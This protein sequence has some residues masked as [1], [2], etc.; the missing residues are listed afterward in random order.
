MKILFYSTMCNFC[1]DL[2]NKLKES[3]YIDEFKLVN[4]NESKIP[5][6]IKVVPTIIDS[7]VKDL[8]EGK[9]AFEYLFNKKYFN[10]PTN[11]LH[12]WLNKEI[13]KPKIEKNELEYE[14]EINNAFTK[15]ND[16]RFKSLSYEVISQEIK[17]PEKI[18]EPE[19]NAPKK[20]IKISNSNL[21]RIRSRR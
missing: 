15:E 13:A 20:Q 3:N 1:N 8:L 18:K 14:T 5:E 16:D 10:N 12:F 21:L 19:N 4:I 11:N 17:E 6:K 7:E 9:K 2:I